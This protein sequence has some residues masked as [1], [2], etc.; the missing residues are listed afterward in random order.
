M[1]DAI[2]D[3]DGLTVDL[4]GNPVL[5]GMELHVSPGEIVAIVGPNGSGKSTLLRC[6]AGLQPATDGQVLVFGEPPADDA[7]FWGRVGLLFEE[8]AWYPALTTREHLE[9]VAAVHAEARM[10]VDAALEEFAL[11]ERADAVPLNLSTGQR[12]RLSLAATL[13]RPSTLLLLDEPERG[14]DAAFRAR[15]GDLLEEYAHEGGTVLMATHDPG[16]AERAR[17]VPPTGVAA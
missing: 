6:V 4:G 1:Y 3:L 9:L 2:I 14:L 7:G 5:R 13:L 16:L 17:R 10:T 11:A 12:Q 15:L 8:P